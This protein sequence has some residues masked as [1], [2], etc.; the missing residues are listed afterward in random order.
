MS[1]IPLARFEL[2]LA[3]SYLGNPRLLGGPEAALR[4]VNRALAQMTRA[5][6]VRKAPAQSKRVT[7]CLEREVRAYSILHPS[8]PQALI[9]HRFNINP[10]RVSE[11][12]NER[13][14]HEKEL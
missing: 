2:E 11:I 8:F 4:H 13:K 14:D 5:K 7:P 6:A 10:G 12:L 3:R 9:A 1:N